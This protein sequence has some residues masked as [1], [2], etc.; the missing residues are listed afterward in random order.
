MNAE[1]FDWWLRNRFILACEAQFPGKKM[2][3]MTN[4]ASYHKQQ[5]TEYYPEG[6]TPEITTKG[7]NAH[8]LRQTG[9]IEIDVERGDEIEGY[10][11]PEDEPASYAHHRLH[12]GAAPSSEV[13]DGTVTARS[14]KGPSTAELSQ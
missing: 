13:L 9:C 4:N 7:L 14:P 8:V 2:I 3:L 5:S 11:V 6:E 10:K 1:G 12:G